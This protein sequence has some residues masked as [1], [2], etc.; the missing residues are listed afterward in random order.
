MRGIFGLLLLAV[1]AVGCATDPS[2]AVQVTFDPA[3]LA[4]EST[5]IELSLVAQCPAPGAVAQAPVAPV[6][7]LELRK[8]NTFPRFRSPKAGTYGLQGRAR[9][10]GDCVVVAAGCAPVTLRAGKGGTL[11]VVLAAVDD[12][13]GCETGA[14]CSAATGAC[15]GM[16]EGS[17]CADAAPAE[18]AGC[19]GASC[20]F[21]C[22]PCD[23]VPHGRTFCAA[24]DTCD[25]ACDFG[26]QKSG[27]ACVPGSATEVVDGFAN[28]GTTSSL[29]IDADGNLHVAYRAT[30]G[31]SAPL[32]YAAK[33]GGQW[34]TPEKIHSQARVD[35]AVA[36]DAAGQ[37]AVAFALGLGEVHVKRWQ[38]DAWQDDALGKVAVAG[39]RFAMGLDP[40]DALRLVWRDGYAVW[41]GTAWTATDTGP[42]SDAIAP[43][44]LVGTESGR[45]AWVTRR[46][47]GGNSNVG[48]GEWDGASLVGQAR[49]LPVNPAQPVLSRLSFNGSEFHFA[50]IDTG[51]STKTI[52]IDI[53]RSLDWAAG[54]SLVASGRIVDFAIV[55]LGAGA[56]GN[57]LIAYLDEGDGSVNYAVGD[58][59][60]AWTVHSLAQPGVVTG[61]ISAGVDPAGGVH[62]F[63]HDGDNGALLHAYAPEAL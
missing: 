44:V 38:G 50:F 40:D 13:N 43:S 23:A 36:V 10:P 48:V 46:Y 28:S 52:R 31:E 17:G 39:S 22:G 8:G 1:G 53:G 51:T 35:F 60:G 34:Q 12:G 58:G 9:R 41:N 47:P 27:A 56:G 57:F 42:D 20:E 16:C 29:A 14:V 3:A 21:E 55:E 45:S 59:E 7:T 49:S 30:N 5:F 26:Y 61:E 32:R 19:D 15:D 54:T 63:F 37:P 18:D 11:A 25:F 62:V 24:E 2:Y 4:E 6:E 33:V